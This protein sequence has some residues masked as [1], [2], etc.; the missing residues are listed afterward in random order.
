VVAFAA[1]FIAVGIFVATL[2]VQ[3]W[4]HGKP[5]Q[6]IFILTAAAVAF[7]G[8]GLVAMVQGLSGAKTFASTEELQAHHPSEPWLWNVEWMN[9][10]ISDHGAAS[11]LS[12]WVGAILV[13]AISSPGVVLARSSFAQNRLAMLVLIFP[14]IA[15]GL[16]IAAIRSTL[17]ARRFRS[18]LVLDTLPGAIG[19]AFRGH[20]QIAGDGQAL[21]SAKSIAVA[22]TSLRRRTTRSGKSTTT[23]DTVLWQDTN[24]LAPTSVRLGPSGAVLPVAFAIPGDAQPVDETNSNDRIVWRVNV[25]ADVPGIDY[26]AHFYVPVFRTTASA[27][28]TIPVTQTASVV[29]HTIPERET[30]AGLRLDF[31]PFRAPSMAIGT[32]LFT[33]L[34]TG[35]IALMIHL[36]APFFFIAIFSLFGLVLVYGTLNLFFGAS[37]V[38]V[39][40]DSV[41][42]APRLLVALPS[43]TIPVSAITEVRLKIREQKS[44][45]NS[46]TAY[47]D[48]EVVTR[49]GQTT[50][51]G[52][53]I[54]DKHEAEQLAGDIRRRLQLS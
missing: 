34:W 13:F 35:A 16:F 9:R 53:L 38:T 36:D 39:S 51:L 30:P 18:V 10:R 23:S 2:A 32:G 20:V 7:G 12:M 27:A 52:N 45:A 50:T 4:L 3:A 47:Y 5:A 44:S 1:P 8:A 22:L 24:N 40:R 46:A 29:P 48:L 17:Q 21:T 15:L 19:G 28:P 11:S 26:S 37:S 43:K 54:R 31:A 41:V 25:D 49:D 14:L 42:V 33:V 6:Q